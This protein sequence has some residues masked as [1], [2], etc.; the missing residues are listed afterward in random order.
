MGNLSGELK[1]QIKI[2]GIIPH[3]L[4]WGILIFVF[5]ILLT[6]CGEIKEEV[7]SLTISP[8]NATVG[9]NQSQ[10]F[11]VIG[12]DDLGAIIQVTP[13]WGTVGGIGTINTNGL[14][15]AGSTTAEGHINASYGGITASAE[16]TVTDKG[17]F[18]GRVFDSKGILVPNL[19]VYLK[20]TGLFDFTDSN[21]NY[22][23]SNVPAGTYEVW[24]LETSVYRAS[25][26]EAMVETGETVTVNFTILY[27]T[28]P[29]DL[30]P[31]DL[32]F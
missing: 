14:F 19:K 4:L 11:T 32:T 24:T 25:S 16:L 18:Q 8:S 15:T 7:K 31:P 28:D 26:K 27:F 13:T 17:W 30:T 1:P 10:L 20:G 22:S 21:A 12:K 6:G 29:P 9:I 5:C 2:W 3:N 23:I